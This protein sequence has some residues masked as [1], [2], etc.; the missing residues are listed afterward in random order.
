[1][2]AQARVRYVRA[3]TQNSKMHLVEGR[4]KDLF[5]LFFSM[6]TIYLIYISKE[7]PGTNIYFMR[8]NPKKSTLRIFCKFHG[9]WH[10]KNVINIRYIISYK[11]YIPYIVI[12]CFVF[13]MTRVYLPSLTAFWPLA[14]EFACWL[15]II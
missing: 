6:K 14:L 12:V 3:N 2:S 10:Y 7:I 8:F 11:Y 1:M 5:C 15:I 9:S 4:T 13:R